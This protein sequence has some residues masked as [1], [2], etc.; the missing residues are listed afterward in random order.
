MGT[1]VVGID[2]SEDSIRALAWAIAEA[3]VRKGKVKAIHSWS[4]PT[5]IVGDDGLPHA[6]LAAS[7]DKVLDDA[8]AAAGDA[9]G[10]EVEREIAN[11]LPAK[12]LIAASK[13]ADLLV[14]GSRGLGGFKGLLLGSVAQ[15]VAHH[16][17]CPVVIVP[18]EHS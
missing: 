15:Q 11:D 18:H 1:I 14:V 13:G 12:A 10:V 4:F 7:A 3:R 17:Q 5:P 6:D 2:G 16:S 8:I 9:G